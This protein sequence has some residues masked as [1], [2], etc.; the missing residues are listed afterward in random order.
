MITFDNLYDYK[1][2]LCNEHTNLV[3]IILN[4]EITTL[5]CNKIST[6]F[7]EIGN[8]GLKPEY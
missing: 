4:H 5:I 8:F 1:I 6:H 2:D 3:Q 7:Y